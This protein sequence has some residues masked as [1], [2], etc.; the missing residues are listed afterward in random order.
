MNATNNY[1]KLN[2]IPDLI[3]ERSNNCIL[4]NCIASIFL[5]ISSL[6][7]LCF[8]SKQSLQIK[9]PKKIYK[10]LKTLSEQG[11]SFRFT[12]FEQ[13][14]L[15]N[16]LDPSWQ[17][18]CNI[19]SHSWMY[20]KM[21]SR[22]F[23]TPSTYEI[24]DSHL[25]HPMIIGKNSDEEADI[26]L[27]QRQ[28]RQSFFEENH[29][30]HC[31][32]SRKM[33]Q[34]GINA[35]ISYLGNYNSHCTLVSSRVCYSEYTQNIGHSCAFVKRG[36]K[37]SWFDP[38]YGEVTFERFK[39]FATWFKLE[40]M[41][42]TQM[43]ILREAFDNKRNNRQTILLSDLF[44]QPSFSDEEQNVNLLSQAIVER[45]TKALE[46]RKLAKVDEL[47]Y[48]KLHTFIRTKNSTDLL[49]F[50]DLQFI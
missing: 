9:Q 45:R 1:Q 22:N 8:S 14:A 2:I 18:S 28:F 19:L 11:I 33:K 32:V 25:P 29:T 34:K 26:Q 36:D 42:G 4:C 50:E 10:H 30:T 3:S 21:R 31:G 17:G 39:D 35:L 6:F 13:G 37:C 48:Y 27:I 7:S 40:V 12:P 38:N 47:D 23:Q 49:E 46:N 15:A 20:K 44:P 43:Y 16:I 41:D 24:T 5:Y